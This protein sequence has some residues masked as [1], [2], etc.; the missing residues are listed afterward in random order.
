MHDWQ[1]P[2]SRGGRKRRSLEGAIRQA[3]S[4]RSTIPM[5]IALVYDCLYPATV[6]GGERWLRA[7]AIA[8]AKDHE[9]TYITRRQWDPGEE[10]IEGVRC[11]AVSP[12]GPLYRKNGGRRAL[13]P[14]LFGI[15]VFW[16]FLRNRRSYDAVHCLSY[17]YLP[18][19]AIRLALAR[20][21]VRVLCEWLECLSESYWAAHRDLTSRIAR[22]LQALC[23]KATPEAVAFS[24]HT[25]AHLRTS[26]YEGPVHLVGGLA[27][28]PATAPMVFEDSRNGGPPLVLFVGRHVPDKR[29]AAIPPAIA[30]A[31]R[32]R[33]D[34]TAVIVGDGPERPRVLDRIRKLQLDGVVSAPGFLTPD[35][36]EQLY[37]RAVC[38]VAPSLRDGYGMV[39]AEAAAHGAPAVVCPG[40]DNAAARRVQEGV[41]GAI[42]AS[43]R[44]ADIGDAIVRVIEQGE[45]LRASV[46]RWYGE[47]ADELS[48]AA[49]IRRTRALYE[50]TASLNGHP[51]K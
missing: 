4:T 8:L 34:V 49:S 35:N 23:V 21:G 45:P 50:R 17:P 14:V 3:S 25:V 32:R 7:L 44:P 10:P 40:H 29:P 30:A 33:H 20:T 51:P 42:A 24:D 38:V 1:R 11:V 15:G 36:L 31:R 27:V 22:R 2:F 37:R 43:E 48:I 18:L 9:V 12:G 46:R 6:G 26:G 13:P 39:V 28:A 41:N 16:H 5:R 19:L 47:H